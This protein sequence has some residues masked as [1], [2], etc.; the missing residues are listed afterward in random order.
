MPAYHEEFVPARER[1]TA[2]LG[3]YDADRAGASGSFVRMVTRVVSDATG[4]S[5]SSACAASTRHPS[6]PSCRAQE[7]GG[8]VGR[9]GRFRTTLLVQFGHGAVVSTRTD[10]PALEHTR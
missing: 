8:L 1:R 3:D 5:N 4:A 9:E 7:G 2:L 10:C 6:Q